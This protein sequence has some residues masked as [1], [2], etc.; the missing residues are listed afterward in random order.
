MSEPNPSSPE[1]GG[2]KGLIYI[3]DDEPMLLEMASVILEPLGYQLRTFRDPEA[4]LSAFIAARP[5]PLLI[6]TDYAMHQLNG[7]DLIASCRQAE[8]K[9]KILMVSGTVGPDIYRTAA[10]KPDGFLAKPY[11]AKLLVDAVKSLLPN[12]S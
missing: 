5:R 8:P 10:Q 2:G 7:M 1:P 11:S 12:Q 4:A 9:Q 6:I 3:V